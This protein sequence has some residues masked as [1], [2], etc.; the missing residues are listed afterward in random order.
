MAHEVMTVSWLIRDGEILLG[1]KK[2]RLGKGLYNGYGGH[3]DPEQDTSLDMTAERE[4]LEETRAKDKTGGIVVIKQEKVG[5]LI[6]TYENSDFVAEL[7]YYVVT[8]FTGKPYETEEMI[9]EWFSLDKIPYSQMWP[10]ALV[11]LPLALAGK[12][13][14]GTFVMDDPKSQKRI[15]SHIAEVRFI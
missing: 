6:V 10:N 3:F 5:I 15:S 11:T 13:F 9:P 2:V 1:F 14:I 7:H 4:F 8:K 12:K